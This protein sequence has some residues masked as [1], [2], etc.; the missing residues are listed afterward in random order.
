MTKSKSISD[1][2]R[3]ICALHIR[4]DSLLNFIVQIDEWLPSVCK[5]CDCSVTFSCQFLFAKMR[6]F[7]KIL[8]EYEPYRDGDGA[9]K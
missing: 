7:R 5:T 2:P 6:D 3:R 8:P 1:P 9:Y 4:K